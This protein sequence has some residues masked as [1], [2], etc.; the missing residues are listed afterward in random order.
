MSSIDY[1]IG[2]HKPLIIVPCSNNKTAKHSLAIEMYD[3]K[4]INQLKHLHQLADIAV[5]SAKYGLID[6]NEK[7]DTYNERLHKRKSKGAEALTD[8]FVAKHMASFENLMRSYVHHKVMGKRKIRRTVYVLLPFDYLNVLDAMLKIAPQSL[9]NSFDFI[10]SRQHRGIG[11]LIGYASKL[12]KEL[13][14]P[15]NPTLFRSCVANLDEAI[16]YMMSGQD[17]GISLHYVNETKNL[18][19]FQYI[20]QAAEAGYKIFVDTGLISALNKGCKMTS[21]I[22][23]YE[24]YQQILKLVRPSARKNFYFVLNDNP[25]DHEKQRN[26][27]IAHRAQ[28]RNIAKHANVILPVHQYAVDDIVDHATKMLDSLGIKDVILGIPT[29]SIKMPDGKP[30][31]LTNNNILKLLSAKRGKNDYLFSRTHCLGMSECNPKFNHMHNFLKMFGVE[32]YFD[33]VRTSSIFTSGQ[34]GYVKKA[35]VRRER[36]ITRV[37]KSEYFLSHI[38]DDTDFPITEIAIEM[39][40]DN[41]CNFAKTWNEQCQRMI[42]K[43]EP[44]KIAESNDEWDVE[45]S[46]YFILAN[47]K[48]KVGAILKRLLWLNYTNMDDSSVSSTEVR[49]EIITEL[50]SRER[51]AVQLNIF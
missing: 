22:E 50:F 6:A 10:I 39:I 11:D 29:R 3:G 32:Q 27:L 42:Q 31:A 45:N 7:I 20:I 28:I 2:K 40:K 34:K 30:I 21:S 4:I 41:P 36:M 26:E 18:S 19:I 48:N 23:I 15:Q 47:A 33:A 37:E 16:G 12:E 5:L 44:Y 43:P 9:T 13:K 49:S 46:F 38:E 14:A 25:M 8:E 1:E 35:D 17:M 24:H 51:R